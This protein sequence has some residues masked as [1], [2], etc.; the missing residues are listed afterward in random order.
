MFLEFFFSF[1]V[2]SISFVENIR[3]KMQN[4]QN[5]K[6]EKRKKKKIL[7]IINYLGPKKSNFIILS[8]KWEN[9]LPKKPLV[10]DR[11]PF[12]LSKNARSNLT[13]NS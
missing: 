4:F 6:I 2:N 1:S 12:F 8:P 5:Q 11:V 13:I 10:I 3:K 7:K 9:S